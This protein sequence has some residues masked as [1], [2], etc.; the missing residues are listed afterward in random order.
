MFFQV[1]D[2]DEEKYVFQSIFVGQENLSFSVIVECYFLI[3]F[4]RVD[5]KSDCQ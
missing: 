2:F 3:D 5:L 1:H 4:A